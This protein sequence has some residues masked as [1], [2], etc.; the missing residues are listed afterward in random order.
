MN[1]EEERMMI[2][3]EDYYDEDRPRLK[4]KVT[5]KNAPSFIK[6]FV[7]TKE[8]AYEI[9]EAMQFAIYAAVGYFPDIYC[10]TEI[11]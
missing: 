9:A 5:I 7:N 11:Q 6:R 10:A 8:Q 1:T 2:L 4:F 3:I